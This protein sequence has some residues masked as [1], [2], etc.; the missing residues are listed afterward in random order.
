[1]QGL[2][3]RLYETA[4]QRALKC[5]NAKGDYRSRA[6][7]AGAITFEELAFMYFVDAAKEQSGAWNL[8]PFEFVHAMTGDA[9]LHAAQKLCGSYLRVAEFY[10][11]TF[12]VRNPLDLGYINQL[13]RILS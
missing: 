9:P 1:M 12:T 2:G 6:A 13:E 5:M 7:A 4:R 3:A 8:T 10:G 11:P